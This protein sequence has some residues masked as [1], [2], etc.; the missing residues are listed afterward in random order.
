MRRRTWQWSGRL[1]RIRSPPPLTAGVG[2]TTGVCHRSD[3]VRRTPSRLLALVAVLLL[4]APLATTAQPATQVARIGCLWSGSAS[5]FSSRL[6]ALREGLRDLG[7]RENQTVALECRFADGEFNRLPA[8]AVEVVNLKPDV[9]VSAAPTR[10]RYRDQQIW[11]RGQDAD[12][13]R[14]AFYTARTVCRRRA[15]DRHPTDQRG[16]VNT[17]RMTDNPPGGDWSVRRP[18]SSAAKVRD[19]GRAPSCPFEASPGG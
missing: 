18:G 6:Q 9:I 19:G 17:N 12:S 10:G 15:R 13:G 8:L 4:A 16:A 5:A 1:A 7:Y 14:R 3:V 11:R 2:Q